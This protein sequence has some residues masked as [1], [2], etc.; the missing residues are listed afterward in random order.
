LLV[1]TLDFSLIYLRNLPA[2]HAGAATF[3]EAAHLSR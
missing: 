3:E 1:K 2:C